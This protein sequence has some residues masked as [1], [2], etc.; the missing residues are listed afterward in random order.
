MKKDDRTGGRGAG[1]SIERA[2]RGNGVIVRASGSRR[3]PR[4]R[5]WYRIR[6]CEMVVS[7]PRKADNRIYL[8]LSRRRRR[9]DMNEKRAIDESSSWVGKEKKIG[10]RMGDGTRQMGRASTA[11]HLR[12][13]SVSES[14]PN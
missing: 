6:G 11:S 4:I 7:R 13:L 5:S 3:K 14:T 10:S 1:M 9:V 12:P 8:S 2:G